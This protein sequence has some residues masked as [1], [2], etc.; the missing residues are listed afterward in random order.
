ML[1][2]SELPVPIFEHSDDSI[3]LDFVTSRFTTA[4]AIQIYVEP[5]KS[6]LGEDRLSHR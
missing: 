1:Y 4:S 5:D 2:S 3:R 6:G